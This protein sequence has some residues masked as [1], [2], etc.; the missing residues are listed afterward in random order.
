M[1]RIAWPVQADSG[2]PQLIEITDG[3]L[4]VSWTALLIASRKPRSVLGAK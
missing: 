1:A 2:P 3:R 4:T